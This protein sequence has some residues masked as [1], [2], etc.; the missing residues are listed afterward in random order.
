MNFPLTTI[1]IDDEPLAISR[2]RRLLAPRAETVTIIGEAR[3]GAEGLALVETERPDLIFLDIEMP[4]LT[5]FELLARLSYMPLVIFATAYDQYA[6][7]AFEENSVDY[8]LK[9][10]ETERLDRSISKLHGLVGNRPAGQLPNAA[11]PYTDNLIRLLEQMKPKKEL[12]SISVKTGEK[13]ILLPLTDIA[14]FEA[15]E[16]YVFVATTDGQKYLTSYTLTNLSERLPDTFVRVSRSAVVN[17]HRIR[18][19]QKQFDG[20]FVLTLTDKK[21]TKIITGSTYADA[22][23]QLL[24]L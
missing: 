24:S 18:E 8:L 17:S 16:K 11:N 3:N 20:K 10:I 14:F 23:R 13:I 15:E 9:P 19:C 4:L 22:V 21:A 5:G 2:L 6:I 1:L 12:Y 7:R